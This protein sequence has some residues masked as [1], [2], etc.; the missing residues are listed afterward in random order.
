MPVRSRR[1][2]GRSRSLASRGQGRFAEEWTA[3]E[4]ED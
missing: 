2:W 1:T 4:G 3:K